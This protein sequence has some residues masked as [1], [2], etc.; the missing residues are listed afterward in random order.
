M[1]SLSLEKLGKKFMTSTACDILCQ[2]QI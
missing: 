2:N 1:F